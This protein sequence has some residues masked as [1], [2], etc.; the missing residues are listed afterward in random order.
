TN[1]VSVRI[2]KTPPVTQVTFS[3]NN[4]GNNG[5]YRGTVQI[6]MSATDNQSGVNTIYYMIDNGTAKVYSA[7]FNYSTN[8]VHTLTYW[9]VDKVLNTEGVRNLPIKIDQNSPN[10]TLTA[11]P[12]SVVAS[13]TPVT[14]TI[15]G[16]LTDSISGVDPLSA[17]FYVID[18]Y[19]VA[20]P[21]GPI[22]L[23]P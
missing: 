9:S 19:V 16:H 2:D 23:Q 21:R 7:P 17:N 18:E 12:A 10:L 20:E 8:G 15:S 1:T 11:T 13:S 6:S 14:V 5:W 3:D 4:A 22:T